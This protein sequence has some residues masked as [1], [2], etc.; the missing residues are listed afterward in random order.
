[1]DELRDLAHFTS[2]AEH[3]QT[4]LKQPRALRAAVHL[5]YFLGVMPAS[6]NFFF[7]SVGNRDRVR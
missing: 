3:R 1:M 4:D 7:G 2:R 5:T 6:R